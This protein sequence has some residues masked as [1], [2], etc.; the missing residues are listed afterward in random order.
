MTEV[1]NTEVVVEETATQK[2]PANNE[3]KQPLYI[4]GRFVVEKE[5]AAKPVKGSNPY[6]LGE[7]KIKVTL[8]KSPIGY[9]KDQIATVAALG[10]KKIRDEMIHFLSHTYNSRSRNTYFIFIIPTRYRKYY[11]FIF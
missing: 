2:T 9:K 11:I 1:V 3:T 8:V 5:L 7:K 4:N 6:E 10:L